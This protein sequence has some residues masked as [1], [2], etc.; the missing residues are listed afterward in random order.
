MTNVVAALR[1]ELTTLETDLRADPRYRKIERIR[2]LLTEYDTDVGANDSEVFSTNS[3]PRKRE[4][5]RPINSK[6]ERVREIIKTVLIE[7]GTAHRSELLKA[8]TE[9][10]VMGSEKDPMASLAAYLSDFREDFKNVG[11]GRW[12][13]V[14]PPITEA[15]SIETEEAS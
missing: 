9:R 6:S 13:L 15:S 4:R 2:A 10:G 12:S 3:P 14:V 11:I 5:T 7:K 1:Q 8:L